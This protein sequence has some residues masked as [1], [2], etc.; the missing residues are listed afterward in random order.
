MK[1][2]D[3]CMNGYVIEGSY[4]HD[5]HSKFKKSNEIVNLYRLRERL[6]KLLQWYDSASG[7]RLG[8]SFRESFYNKFTFGF[9][10]DDVDGIPEKELMNKIIEV[11]REHMSEVD[12]KIEEL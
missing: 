7:K 12:K 8:I 11:C 3:D 9:N 1:L 5:I 2:R 4:R 10:D 6:S